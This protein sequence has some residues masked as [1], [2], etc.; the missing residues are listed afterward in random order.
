MPRNYSVNPLSYGFSDLRQ[1][2]QKTPLSSLEQL[3]SAL[4]ILMLTSH[5]HTPTHIK[6]IR[7]IL[8]LVYSFDYEVYISVKMKW[9]Y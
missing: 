4:L 7:Y 9:A 2:R 6:S 8:S 3:T 5:L 1:R